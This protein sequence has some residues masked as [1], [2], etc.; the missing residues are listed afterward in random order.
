MCIVSRQDAEIESTA[1]ASTSDVRMF[2]ISQCQQQQM[3][4]NNIKDN[5][6]NVDIPA[7]KK[8][9]PQQEATGWLVQDLVLA[10]T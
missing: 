8:L 4:Q 6:A 7:S 1:I 10:E 5:L 3:Y 2:L 9:E